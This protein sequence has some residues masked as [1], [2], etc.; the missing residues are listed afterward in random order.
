MM[1]D[2]IIMKPSRNGHTLDLLSWEERHVDIIVKSLSNPHH[3][4][5]E[6]HLECGEEALHSLHTAIQEN[7]ISYCQISDWGNGQQDYSTVTPSHKSV[8]KS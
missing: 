7:F 4:C 5:L 8:P 3:N 1:H 2:I 6:K